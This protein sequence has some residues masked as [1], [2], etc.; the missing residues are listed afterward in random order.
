MMIVLVTAGD[1]E[2]RLRSVDAALAGSFDIVILAEIALFALVA[3]VLF[4]GADLP[5]GAALPAPLGTMWV[6]VA[7]LA[8]SALWAP[9]P[10]LGIVRSAQLV[11]AA[12]LAT[13][14]G[15][16]ADEA[17]FSRIAHA[18][19][20]LITA[21]IGIG[22]VWHVAPSPLVA[23]RFNWAA[24]HPVT[25]ASLLTISVLTLLSWMRTD[26]GPR[27]LAPR[28]VRLLLVVHTAALLATQTRGAIFAAVVGVVT[29]AILAIRRRRDVAL[30]VLLGLPVLVVLGRGIFQSFILRGE[31]TAQL[32]SLNS[33]T[34][35]W[36]EAIRLVSESPYLGRGYFSARGL[37]LESIGLGGAHN[38]YIEVLISAGLVG[39][40]ALTIVLIRTT[41]ILAKMGRHPQRPLL[42]AL[43]AAMVA[44][45]LTTQYWAQGGTGSNVWFLLLLGW[46]AAASRTTSNETRG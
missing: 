26:A 15:R 23:G 31:S 13:T 44:N 22:L 9:S 7:I 20:L 21:F 38:A 42:G 17:D 18:Y 24:T 14:L 10:T 27:L 11:I 39:V 45:G 8:V 46:I 1:F 2:Y 19:V 29:W 33:R 5:R 36:S 30:F 40:I 25:A 32:R 3:L 35:L 12:C 34:D 28:T 4:L 43:F 16:R 41:H 37:F 6:L